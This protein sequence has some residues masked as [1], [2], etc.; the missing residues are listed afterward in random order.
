MGLHH[1]SVG[2]FATIVDMLGI[3]I[4]VDGVIFFS[5]LGKRS[6]SGIIGLVHLFL[7]YFYIIFPSFYHELK[8]YHV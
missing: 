5:I 2:K 8:P 4:R 6:L 7:I 1:R 3:A